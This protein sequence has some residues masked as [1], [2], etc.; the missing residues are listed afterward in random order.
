LLEP[1][2]FKQ[3]RREYRSAINHID[4][5]GIEKKVKI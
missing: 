4:S 3:K 5:A 1:A 2:L